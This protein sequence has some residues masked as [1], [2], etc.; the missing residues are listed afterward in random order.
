MADIALKDAQWQ[1]WLRVSS[2]MLVVSTSSLVGSHCVNTL[3]KEEEENDIFALGNLLSSDSLVL[4]KVQQL[5]TLS[6]TFAWNRKSLR[7]FLQKKKRF[8]YLV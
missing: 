5:H 4:Y 2:L 8:V 1:P 7:I 6:K 3:E